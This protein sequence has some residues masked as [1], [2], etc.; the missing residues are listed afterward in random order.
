MNATATIPETMRNGV[1][2]HQ[3][4]GT[5]DAVKA[6]PSI[7]KFRCSTSPRAQQRSAVFD[8]VTTACP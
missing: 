7:A 1:D 5:L 8:M 4:F 6:D 3:L 2:T